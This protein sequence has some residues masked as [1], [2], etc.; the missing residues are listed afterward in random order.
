MP[1]KGNPD[2]RA[3][4]TLMLSVG[5]AALLILAV[6][7]LYN[8][9][10]HGQVA[11]NQPIPRVDHAWRAEAIDSVTTT[12]N[13]NYVYPDV[14][15]KMEKLVRQNLK[16]GKYDTLNDPLVFTRVLTEDL[17]SVS[18]DGHL[19][20][21]YFPNLAAEY[22]PADTLTDS[23][24][25]V[26]LEKARFDNYG[27]Y[28][29]ERLPGNIGYLDLRYF[30]EAAEAGAIAVAAMNFLSNCDA[31]IF[32]MRQ[33]GGGWPSMIQLITTYLF[34]EPKHLNSLYFRPQD[35]IYQFWT[36]PYV[37]GRRM[38]NIDVYILTSSLTFSGAEE[39]TF[40]LKNLKRATI[41][42]ET[43]GGGAH[44]TQE[45]AFLKLNVLVNV[46]YGRAINPVTNTNWE[47]TGVKPDIEVPAA[48]ALT[49]ARIE[50]LKKL[51]D[52][53]VDEHRKGRYEWELQAQETELNP[54]QI[55]L[56]TLQKYA[57]TYGPR[58]FTLENGELFY[59]REGRPKYKMI[60]ITTMVFQPE[61][62]DYFRLKFM[63]N[64]QGVVTEVVGLYEDGQEDR[65]SR[66][67]N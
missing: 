57:G 39:F 60:P 45:R 46:P 56:G 2:R 34:D 62:L 36:L 67:G 32:D 58:K 11:P 4:A 63:T 7:G 40:N 17:R 54:I 28:R 43:T 29:V 13:A 3:A 66:T 48:Q 24:R 42:G 49:V 65:S 50:A 33:N 6:I 59:Q 22:T 10:A 61:G 8:A 23:I 20:I 53:A 41:I 26:Q 21:Q 19:G 52:K 25:Q 27:F 30:A 12:L 14:A 55:D 35:T 5:L 1:V 38:P 16:Q 9:T 15:K 44:W 18:H 47:G 51:R 31:L 37:S 64:E